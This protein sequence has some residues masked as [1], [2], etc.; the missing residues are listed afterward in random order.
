[1]IRERLASSPLAARLARAFEGDGGGRDVLRMAYPLVLSHMSFTLQTFVDRVF[2]TWYSPTAMAGAVTGMFAVWSVVGLFSTT[3]EYLTTFVAQY[4]GAG[5]PRRIGPA[6]WQGIY[7]ALLAGVVLAALAPLA[8]PFFDWSG[9]DPSLR[10]PEVEYA[11]TLL[12][13]GLPTVLMA[14]LSSFYSGRG[15][16]LLVLRV[17]VVVT[18][19]NLVLDPLMIFGLL[20][21]PKA[22]VVGAA[23]ATV[24]SQ[25][26]GA[27]LYLI[28]F[29]RAEARERYATLSARPD[30]P[31]L[32]RLL[33]FG[34]PSGLQ[35][36]M[37]LF[38]FALFLLIVGRIGTLELAATTIAFNLN[39]LV[40]VPMLGLGV[41]IS[42]L[43]GR[44]L[45][46][47]R[48][49]VAERAT[50]T[51]LGLAFVYMGFW[52]TLYLAVPEWLLSPYAVGGGAEAF[53]DLGALGAFLLRFV[54]VYSIFDMINLT[55][56][57]AL[58]GAGDTA[59]AMRATVA[60]A[61]GVMLGPA[62]LACVVL[63]AG[64][65]VAWSAASGYVVVLGLLLLRRF[66]SGHWKTLRVIEPEAP[67]LH[68]ERETAVG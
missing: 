20:G 18:A 54:A 5:R 16:T 66:R 37:E 38:A 42:A 60:L 52:S 13:G 40:F 12:A 59:F 58:R 3:G 7:F 53:R 2:L 1:M 17:N 50:W 15:E 65:F 8:Q 61:F 47:E 62:Y 23:I 26:V 10:E 44:Y 25:A 32:G 48:P 39:G 21:F 24:I 35:F 56:A 67:G 68:P 6:V 49:E 14:T 33:R 27:S 43:V 4:Q 9:H 28:G 34:L 36:S 29:L 30:P 55:C 64:V 46:A 41:G 57:S 22:G 63:G 51:G 11:R 31:L 19:V 45:G